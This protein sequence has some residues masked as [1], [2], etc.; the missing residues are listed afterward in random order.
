MNYL[1]PIEEK[2]Y[3]YQRLIGTGGIGS[4]IL[5]NLDGDHT[6]GRNESRSGELTPFR[7]YCK[8]HIIS[9]YPTV[10]LGQGKKEP[11]WNC[12]RSCRTPV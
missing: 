6:M 5:F 9:H 10:L 8:L 4:G 12:P 1:L 11:L 3:K 2:G 7:D